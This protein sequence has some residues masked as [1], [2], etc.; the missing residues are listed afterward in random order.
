[1]ILG[2]L[3]DRQKQHDASIQNL[4]SQFATT[5]SEKNQEL[6]I[7]NK[8]VEQKEAY[9]KK[10]SENLTLAQ[11]NLLQASQKHHQDELKLEE[12]GK[13]IFSEQQIVKKKLS[14][15]ESDFDAVYAKLSIARTVADTVS[16]EL[17][18]TNVLLRR[19]TD[20][21]QELG[22]KVEELERKLSQ[23]QTDLRLANIAVESRIRQ[24][25]QLKDLKDQH[26]A[27]VHEFER[28]IKTANN[29]IA[30]TKKH[31]SVVIASRKLAFDKVSDDLKSTKG[32]LEGLKGE[33]AAK[34]HE[35]EK[36]IETAHKKCKSYSMCMCLCVYNLTRCSDVTLE[37]SVRLGLRM[38]TAAQP[39]VANIGQRV[40][41]TIDLLRTVELFANR[42]NL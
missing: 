12:M 1:L 17:Q 15:Y 31:V 21:E 38:Q 41:A 11:N 19:A 33:H 37:Q 35:F 27:E 10:L 20:S 5:L 2:L 32:Q 28:K 25:Q 6:A 29:E 42:S 13:V 23:S 40:A 16:A 24:S 3:E 4:S 8:S 36:T 26:A 34:V 9:I 14:R 22:G 18:C 30:F 7:L 39:A